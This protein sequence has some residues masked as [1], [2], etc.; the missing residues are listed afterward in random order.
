MVIGRLFNSII[1]YLMVITCTDA[2]GQNGSN[3]CKDALDSSQIKLY[4]R[5]DRRI[6]SLSAPEFPNNLEA[7]QVVQQYEKLKNNSIHIACVSVEFDIDVKGRPQ[8]IKMINSFPS[9][10]FLNSAIKAIEN[11]YFRYDESGSNNLIYIVNY[12]I[13]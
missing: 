6:I 11:S 8:N 1:F 4:N 10:G 12:S 5:T 13:K 7:I 3:K 2:F 9:Q